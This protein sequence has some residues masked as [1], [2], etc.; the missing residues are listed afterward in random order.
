[1]EAT[2]A[3]AT[4]GLG[5]RYGR[6]WALVDVSLQV[7][8]G[9]AVMVAGRNGSGKSTLLRVLA[10]AIAPT[11]GTARVAGLDVS[12]E[13]DEVR[14]RTALLAHASYTYEALTALEN[15]ALTARFLRR[16]HGREPLRAALAEVGLAERGD[17]AVE[18]FSAGMR[19]R[20]AL[21]RVLMQPAEVVLLDEPYGQLD[22]PGFRLVDRLLAR[23]RQEGRTVLMATHLLERGA[24]LCDRGLVLDG[25]RL[26]WAGPA[27][28]LPGEGIAVSGLAE[29][30]AS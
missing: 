24:D 30:A 26:A 18:T 22:P 7:P 28:D 15:L 14:E 29:G 13:R 16:G 23:L 20:L 5:R 27:A 3:V 12:S 11:R 6:R 10:T 8:R 17:D 1:M 21:A 19:R 4:D 9:A 25:G 2:P